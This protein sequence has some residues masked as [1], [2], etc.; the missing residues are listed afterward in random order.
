VVPRGRPGLGW[1]R[2]IRMALVIYL[3]PVILLVIALGSFLVVLEKFIGF[4]ARLGRS[5]RSP[6]RP[7][8]GFT[9]RPSSS[10]PDRRIHGLE[11]S[12]RLRG[13]RRG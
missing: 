13:L 3:S 4:S 7:A 5:L 11:M 9:G 2:L 10:W 12:R 8:G 1:D 6:A